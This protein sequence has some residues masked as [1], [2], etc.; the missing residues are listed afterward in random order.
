MICELTEKGKGPRKGR[1]QEREGIGSRA[2]KAGTGSRPSTRSASRVTKAASRLS[3]GSRV[4]K[5]ATGSR[6]ST[7]STSRARKTTSRPSTNG[8]VRGGS[9]EAEHCVEGKEGGVEGG[10]GI[11]VG[12]EASKRWWRRHRGQ[13]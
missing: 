11:G 10:D 9:V 3:S 4:R 2:R 12:V 13:D 5:V 6:T 7:G 1:D 8:G